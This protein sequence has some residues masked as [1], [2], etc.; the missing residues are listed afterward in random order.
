M[1]DWRPTASVETLKARAGIVERIRSFFSERGLVEVSTPV[2]TPCGVTDPNI[3]SIA[4]SGQ[5]AW[6]RTSPEF[7]HKRLLAAGCGDLFELGPAFRF[8]ERGRLHQTEFTLLEWYRCGWEWSELAAEAVE[9][10]LECVAD[11]QRRVPIH[12]R[13]W[14][15]CFESAVN[16]NPL[17][18]GTEALEAAADN[19]PPDCTR[20]MLLD[21]LFATRIHPLFDA[22]SVTVVFDYPASQAAL[23]RLKPDDPCLAERFEIFLGPMELANGY[24]ELTCSVEQRARFEADNLT[25]LA[26]DRPAM[27]IDDA[28]LGALA[29]GLPE[30]AGIALGVDRLVMAALGYGHIA[31]VTTFSDNQAS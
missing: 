4:L 15:D 13:S 26:L 24:R 23:A 14:T 25:R 8:G 5:A 3:E 19:A 28:L 11:G 6:L 27:P 17:S 18:A 1:N 22:D 21:F 20:D 2:I 31:Q 30:C 29:A 7:W 10:I 9:L 16:L 12:Y